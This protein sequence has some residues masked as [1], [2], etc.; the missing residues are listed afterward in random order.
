M[1]CINLQMHNLY[2]V[3]KYCR[4]EFFKIKKFNL[5]HCVLSK[6]T[7]DAHAVYFSAAC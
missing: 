6:Y 3:V 7:S 4:L 2:S 1:I 5:Q